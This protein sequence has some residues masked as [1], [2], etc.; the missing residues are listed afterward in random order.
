MGPGSPETNGWKWHLDLKAEGRL[1]LSP[2]QPWKLLPLPGQEAA[3]GE[4]LMEE[5]AEE[6]EEEEGCWAVL[7]SGSSGNVSGPTLW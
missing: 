7:G 3:E 1:S 2:R 6:E 5:E 4:V